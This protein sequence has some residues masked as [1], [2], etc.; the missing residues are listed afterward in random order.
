MSQTRFTEQ[1]LTVLFATFQ[2]VLRRRVGMLVQTSSENVEDACM[3]TWT[4]LLAGKLDDFD[5]AEQWLLLVARNESLK[6]DRRGKRTEPLLNDD[7]SPAEVV[8]PHDPIAARK[9]A[10]E[11]TTAIAAAGLSA[12]E[13]RILGL[14]AFGLMREEIAEGTGETRRSVERQLGRAHRKLRENFQ[15]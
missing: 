12:R 9:R 4:Q 15:P 11:V 6:L 2:P 10:I 3:F 14:Q 5:R 13:A 8:D 7:G 1:Q